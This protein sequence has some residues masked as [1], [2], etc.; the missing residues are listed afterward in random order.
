MPLETNGSPQDGGL[1][2]ATNKQV[3]LSIE[4]FQSRDNQEI[5][6]LID[7]LLECGI[8][9]SIEIPQASRISN[10]ESL[11]RPSDANH[12]AKI[13]DRDHIPF[14][15]GDGLCTR[16]PTQIVS[17]RA[18]SGPER[19]RVSIHPGLETV[20]VDL[21]AFARTLQSLTSAEF[22]KLIME[23]SDLLGVAQPDELGFHEDF[24][25]ENFSSST[26]KIEV[27]GPGRTPFTITDLPG[28]FHTSTTSQSALDITQIQT[29]VYNYIR[30]PGTIIV[31]VTNGLVNVATQA[32]FEMARKVDA[33]GSRTVGV[34]TKCDM[35]A[36]TTEIVKLAQN[37][38]LPLKKHG[39]FVV[40]NR[41]AGEL[42]VDGRGIT[43]EE[44]HL[45]ETSLFSASP[46]T[47]LPKTHRGVQAL[48]DYLSTLLLEHS[49][50][51]LP[52]IAQVIQSLVSETQSQL[53]ELGPVLDSASRQRQFL[54]EVAG[55]FQ[56]AAESS[57]NGY[58]SSS[59]LLKDN[60]LKLRKRIVEENEKFAC[61]MLK[62]GHV[63]EF[64]NVERLPLVSTN[65]WTS[66]SLARS[67][68]I[69]ENTPAPTNS[70][71]RDTKPSELFLD[72]QSTKPSS[73]FGRPWD[74]WSDPQSTRP[75][76]EPGSS[77]A[78]AREAIDWPTPP[79]TIKRHFKA[80][81]GKCL[82]RKEVPMWLCPEN[83]KWSFEE[84]RLVDYE[85]G[86]AS[87]LLPP[88]DGW[89]REEISNIRGT[90]LPG[91]PNQEV[92]PA[93]F[94]RQIRDWAS[95]ANEHLK[96][97]E[98]IVKDVATGL[99]DVTCKDVAVCLSLKRE[100]YLASNDAF[101]RGGEQL[102]ALIQDL[103]EKPL[104]TNNPLF[105]RTIQSARRLRF[106]N[107]L[108]HYL[109][110]TGQLSSSGS[111]VTLDPSR[112]F[113]ALHIS[114]SE[115]LVNEIHDTLKAYY[116]LA[117]VNFIEVVNN[118][119]AERCVSAPDGPMIF[120][121]PRWIAGLEDEKLAK[122][123]SE[124]EETV[125]KRKEKEAMLERLRKAEKILADYR[126]TR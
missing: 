71:L 7:R 3:C 124:S 125:A 100:V 37:H 72:L 18:R 30:A 75:S 19:I 64:K 53:R 77:G 43:N 14:P 1:Q 87:F 56:T 60:A 47:G 28:L 118:H 95:H 99:L 97:I 5:L 123:A 90:E 12:R 41:S 11:K 42:Q 8:N 122:L 13:S 46:W 117:V 33:D 17:R 82:E 89:I 109:Q 81:V 69:P 93:L 2:P 63:V 10:S 73:A 116:D 40:R 24:T 22:D 26:L 34:I 23:A 106:E 68:I 91:M 115:N 45:R 35:V 111:G 15:V 85:E 92:V 121:S 65:S 86:A 54:L 38:T 4:P 27:T 25:R 107:A 104:Q 66:S 110:F 9:R 21:S 105:S 98:S 80:E 83:K 94:R 57:L 20:G 39:W 61:K 6:D 79:S 120:F 32:V 88:I 78:M 58:Y 16:F 62:K 102:A 96:S 113:D 108:A 55:E 51:K 103:H 36:D 119:I 76:D 74:S 59:A 52:K 114:N 48:R 44:R 29:M 126:S 49:R 101:G 67:P 70:K 31:G 112:L 84:M 50:S